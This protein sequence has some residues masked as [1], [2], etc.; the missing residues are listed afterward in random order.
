MSATFL[1][2]AGRGWVR[3]GSVTIPVEDPDPDP[4]EPEDENPDG[5]VRLGYGSTPYGQAPYGD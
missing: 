4:E 5:D 2:L 1:R 3:K